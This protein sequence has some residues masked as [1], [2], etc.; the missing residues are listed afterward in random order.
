[1]FEIRLMNELLPAI[2][3]NRNMVF[4]VLRDALSCE[5]NSILVEF[6]DLPT[7]GDG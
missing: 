1:M 2:S 6:L 3:I 5:M 7:T 4:I